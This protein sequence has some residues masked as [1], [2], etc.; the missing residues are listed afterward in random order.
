M[1][2]ITMADPIDHHTPLIRQ[3]QRTL[4]RMEAAM[5]VIQD[6]LAIADAESRLLWCN[7]PFQRLCGRERLECLGLPVDSLLPKAV[8]GSDLI[9]AL[10][11]ADASSKQGSQILILSHE[12]LRVIELQW[13]PIPDE[14]PP[15]LIFCIRDISTLISY[16][17][18]WA[19]SESLQQR[20]LEIENLNDRLRRSQQ[21]LAMQVRECPLTRL[22]NRRGLIRS[23]AWSR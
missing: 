10:P 20:S 17:Q 11:T 16:Q 23:G 21:H 13:D 12:P 5:A 1:A 2:A 18:L 7:E 15:A 22:P 4:G 9:S 6:A 8:D 14:Q 19:R 3:L